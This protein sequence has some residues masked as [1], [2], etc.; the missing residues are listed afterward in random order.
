[1]TVRKLFCSRWMCQT[2]D[3]L[4]DDYRFPS[5]WGKEDRTIPPSTNSLPHSF[6]HF[7]ICSILIKYILRTHSRRLFT[8]YYGDHQFQG[9]RYRTIKKKVKQKKERGKIW[10]ENE[11]LLSETTLLLL[12]MFLISHFVPDLVLC[13]FNPLGYLIKI[14]LLNSYYYHRSKKVNLNAIEVIGLECDSQDFNLGFLVWNA[15]PSVYLLFSRKLLM[16]SK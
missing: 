15:L 13:A 4:K 8:K 3:T 12:L 2:G 11:H 1:M 5:R 7:L 10:D 6:I 9:R 14:T 16:S